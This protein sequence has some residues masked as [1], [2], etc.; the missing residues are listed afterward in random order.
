MN[1]EQLN[2]VHEQQHLHIENAWMPT[3]NGS[4]RVDSNFRGLLRLV[5]CSGT[6]A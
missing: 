5:S 2:G 6:H 4:P 3:V 1:S